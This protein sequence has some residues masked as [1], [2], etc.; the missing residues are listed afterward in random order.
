MRFVRVIG[1]RGQAETRAVGIVGEGR[2]KVAP[3]LERLAQGVVQV[4]PVLVGQVPARELP[5]HRRFTLRRERR[6]LEIGEAP[7]GL[8]EPGR[9]VQT[10]IIRGDRLLLMAGRS[11]GVT[12]AEPDL[13]LTR[14]FSQYGA[15]DRNGLAIVADQSQARSLEVAITELRRV[16]GQQSIQVDQGLLRLLLAIEHHREIVARAREP[17]RQLQATSEEGLGVAVAGQPRAC[18]GQHA[19][20]G[21]V[22]GVG[23]QVIAQQP[24]G[25][26]EAVVAKRVGGGH[27]GLVGH[28]RPD[29]LRIGG[30]GAGPV[31][32]GC[33]QIADRPPGLR[34]SAL[35]GHRPA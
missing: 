1:N 33:Q 34:Q 28:R 31:T 13:G 27:Q 30:V 18:L 12:I 22:G 5:A 2:G 14:I 20:R 9:H 4:Q 35:K 21:H 10:A 25:D 32:P 3:V 24:F 19:H 26:R 6:R 29:Q 17:R 23:V 16:V 11:Q 8:A 15:V 7:V